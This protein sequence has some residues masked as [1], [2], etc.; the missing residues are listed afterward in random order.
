M[1]SL[2]LPSKEECLALHKKYNSPKPVIEHCLTVTKIAENFCVQIEGI[3]RELVVAGAMLHD[4]GRVK[5]HSIFHAVEGVKILEKEGLN[6]KLIQIVKKHIGTGI[7]L[8]EAVELGLPPDDYIPKTVEEIVVS[9]ADKL[10]TGDRE[11][12]FEEALSRL[13]VK[14]G[15]DSHVVKGLYKQKEYVE[16]LIKDSLNKNKNQVR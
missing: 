16:K 6:E 2:K 13:I 7:L 15:K 8:A 12:S 11:T 9:Y 10:A 5:S 4:I 14:F 3:D 1:Q